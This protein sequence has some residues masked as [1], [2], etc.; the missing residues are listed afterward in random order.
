M[1]GVLNVPIGE[2][3][4]TGSGGTP[5]RDQM[6]K[7]YDGGTIPWVKSGEL[8]ESVI[9]A[10]EEYVTEA[11]LKETS[12]TLVPANALLVAMYGATVGLLGIFGVPATTNQ[13]IVRKLTV[14]LPPL[15]KA[16]LLY[17]PPF[18]SYAPTGPDALFT[19]A[20]VDELFGV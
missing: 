2:F 1:S 8:R 20:Q 4:Q 12:V 7:Y 13:G 5:A 6:A 9:N 15:M 10:T 3:C 18:T 16:S 11:A 17:E 19:S 14:P